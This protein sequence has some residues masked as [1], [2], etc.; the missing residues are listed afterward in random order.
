[1][2]NNN[3]TFRIVL[4]SAIT[5]VTVVLLLL[6]F[7]VIGKS[8]STS[9]T[10][11]ATDTVKFHMQVTDGRVTKTALD[12]RTNVKFL[13]ESKE[14]TQ[15]AVQQPVAPPTQQQQAPPVIQQP[16]VVQIPTPHRQHLP[17]IPQKN[18]VAD[19]ATKEDVEN[20][21]K[22]IVSDVKT[23]VEN[24][25]NDLK[26][27]LDDKFNDV[28]NDLKKI[29]RIG[30]RTYTEVTS[31]RDYWESPPVKKQKMNENINETQKYSNSSPGNDWMK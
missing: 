1:M 28:K 6:L 25:S 13:Y 27:Y 9:T 24:S 30:K 7:G 4:I 3:L 22:E 16:V 23:I 2:D 29:K 12:G 11:I 26:D 17:Y 14:T 20:A 31:I 21:K 19:Y 8:S 18:Y 15:P 5:L 10:P